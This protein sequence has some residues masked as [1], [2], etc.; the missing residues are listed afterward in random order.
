MEFL[1][2]ARVTNRKTDNIEN[3]PKPENNKVAD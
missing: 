3:P 2:H 1:H